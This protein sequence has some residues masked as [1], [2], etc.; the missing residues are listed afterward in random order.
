MTME[1]DASVRTV[2][3]VDVSGGRPWLGALQTATST[4][5]IVHASKTTIHFFE[6]RVLRVRSLRLIIKRPPSRSD[7]CRT[8]TKTEP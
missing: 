1:E 8:Q 6:G 3:Q 7:V 2:A 4:A 5:Y